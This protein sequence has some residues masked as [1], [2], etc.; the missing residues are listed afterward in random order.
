ML[1]DRLRVSRASIS[2]LGQRESR[3][4]R[5]SG[6]DL[7]WLW[8]ISSSRYRLMAGTQSIYAPSRLTLN[9]LLCGMYV[10]NARTPLDDAKNGIKFSAPTKT[11]TAELYI[12]HL[13]KAIHGLVVKQGCG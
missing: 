5:H 9:A 6:L 8:G 1:R 10:P 4:A 11:G 3:D 2:E 7:P 13:V 12:L